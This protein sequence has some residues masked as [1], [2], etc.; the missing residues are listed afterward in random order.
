MTIDELIQKLQKIK[1]V[2]YITGDEPV[3]IV[4]GMNSMDRFYVYHSVHE[5][6]E[7][8]AYI[9]LANDES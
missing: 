1:E 3:V 8:A 9:D 4:A 6:N 2:A 5:K 7:Y